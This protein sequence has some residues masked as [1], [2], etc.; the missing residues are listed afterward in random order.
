MSDRPSSG[1]AVRKSNGATAC[2]L[3]ESIDKVCEWVLT[4]LTVMHESEVSAADA[5][6]TSNVENKASFIIEIIR[7]TEFSY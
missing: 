5:T 3:F 1:F 4:E 2:I 6:A 7:N